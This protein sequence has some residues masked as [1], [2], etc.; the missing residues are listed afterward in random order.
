MTKEEFY[1]SILISDEEKESAE[2]F[3]YS[4][5]LM[6]H[7]FIRDRISVWDNNDIVDYSKIASTY[8]YDK[9]IR[10]VLFKY[11]SYLEEF[12]RSLIL[13]EYIVN[14]N[15]TFWIKEI[16][17][18]LVQYNNDLNKVLEAI[19]FKSLL[20]QIKKLPNN[21]K[22][23]L[24]LPKEHLNINLNALRV[25]RNTVMHNKFLVLYRGFEVC[26]VNGVDNGKSASLKAN[27]LNLINF[28]PN[29]PKEKCIVDI[30]ECILNKNDQDDVKWNLPKEIIIKINKV[31]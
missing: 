9:R 23:F 14:T 1:D 30:N 26:Y 10:F 28:L 13:D 7:V 19:D 18:E 15:Q 29:G 20:Q 22:K 25:F 12:Y 6:K 31:K 5:G 17:E 2:K 27:I 11:I 3:I 21:L 16:K 8:R 4:K 24:F